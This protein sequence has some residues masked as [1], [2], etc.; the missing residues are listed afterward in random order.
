MSVTSELKAL[1][2]KEGL[3]IAEEAVEW[4]RKHPKS[5]LHA[6]LEWDDTE[7]AHQYRLYQMRKIIHVSVTVETREPFLVSL[8]VDRTRP[9]GGYRALSDVLRN[10]G[11]RSVLLNDARTIVRNARNRYRQLSEMATIW[12]AIDEDEAKEKTADAAAD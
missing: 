6:S 7:A 2:N 5:A 3:V 10:E 1:Q 12:T 11:Y 9:G 8:T 4:A